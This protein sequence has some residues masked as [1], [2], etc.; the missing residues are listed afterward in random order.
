MVDLSFE[1]EFA[2]KTSTKS[3]G[4]ARKKKSKGGKLKKNRFWLLG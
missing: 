3:R 2:L 1:E 4:G